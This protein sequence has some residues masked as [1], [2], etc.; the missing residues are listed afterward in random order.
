MSPLVRPFIVVDVVVSPFTVFS[1][2]GG[3]PSGRNV[4]NSRART[5]PVDTVS[6]SAVSSFI[7][8]MLPRASFCGNCSSLPLVLSITIAPS[9]SAHISR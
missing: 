4:D 9:S 1:L 5:G 6:V 8:S 7:R 3:R 2:G